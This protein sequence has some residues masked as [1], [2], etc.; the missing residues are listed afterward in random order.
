MSPRFPPE[1]HHSHQSSKH[2]SSWILKN[3]KEAV[4]VVE[5]AAEGVVDPAEVDLAEGV[6]AVQAGE[7][8]RA[9][10]GAEVVQAAERTPG[11]QGGSSRSGSGSPRAYGGGVYYPG[12]AG[13]PYTAGHKTKKG[14]GPFVFL[15]LAALA[16]FPGVWLWGAYAYQGGHYTY[17]NKS[18]PNANGTQIPVTCLC[19]KFS[20]CGCEENQD[21]KY[22]KDLIKQVDKDGFPM[23]TSTIRVATVNGTQSIYVNG[24][25]ANGTTNPDPNAEG[26]AAS[27][28]PPAL[29]RVGGYWVMGAIAVAAVTVL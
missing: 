1:I 27:N 12:G 21:D 14:L 26:A 22:F 18:I 24:T 9:E 2:P 16:F 5:E 11:H 6:E 25:L 20:V 29:L 10:E 15:P 4:V 13:V 17:V 23:N 8:V 19:Q 3:A 7:G 28:A